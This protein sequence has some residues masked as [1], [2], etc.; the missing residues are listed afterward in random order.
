VVIEA[1][2]DD[3][4]DTGSG[5]TGS[6]SSSSDTSDPTYGAAHGANE[7]GGWGC[8]SMGALVPSV[9]FWGALL[10]V[11]WRRREQS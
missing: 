1:G 4:G 2:D 6:G 9:S 5:D 3:T 8:A 11:A 7:I 10:A